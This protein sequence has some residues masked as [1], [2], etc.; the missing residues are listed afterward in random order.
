MPSPVLATNTDG[1]APL[2]PWADEPVVL[3]KSRAASQFILYGNVGDRM[4][5][6]LGDRAELGSLTEFLLR[7]LLP[8]FD[9][10]LSYDLGNGV[11]I[12]KG[13]E[14]FAEWPPYKQARAMPPQPRAAVEAMT[15]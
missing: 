3:Y 4:V 2:P 6:P 13:F 14:L 9:V 1:P 10:V 8:N 12:E 15:Q 11:R 5:L 7:V